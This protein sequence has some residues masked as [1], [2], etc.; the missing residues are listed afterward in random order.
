M[1][2]KRLDIS[3]KKSRVGCASEKAEK[4]SV[5]YFQGMC[6]TLPYFSGH[7]HF[8]LSFINSTS[9]YLA[10]SAR[11]RA[12]KKATVDD[13]GAVAGTI[14]IPAVKLAQVVQACAVLHHQNAILFDLVALEASF[15]FTPGTQ[16]T[17]THR[18]I[19]ATHPV[20]KCF[21]DTCFSS[22]H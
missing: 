20:S 13:F 14:S 2:Q 10:R 3:E 12:E 1:R 21:E 5:V 18:M 16:I 17:S 8:W 15:F 19:N 22:K 9:G 6:T 7:M 11:L 4:H